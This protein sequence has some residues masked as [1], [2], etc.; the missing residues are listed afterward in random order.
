VERIKGVNFFAQ[1]DLGKA[2]VSE[3][4]RAIDF[5]SERDDFYSIVMPPPFA[6]EQLGLKM[7]HHLAREQRR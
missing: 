1:L 2:A 5:G 7:A 6:V 3:S 4:N